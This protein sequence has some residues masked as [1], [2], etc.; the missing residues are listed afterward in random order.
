MKKKVLDQNYIDKYKLGLELN[1]MFPDYFIP[2]YTMV[3][4]TNIPYNK[5]VERNKMQDKILNKILSYDNIPKKDVLEDIVKKNIPKLNCE[6]DC[7]NNA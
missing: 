2:E 7:W 1:D 5:V 3:S 4:F 6:K